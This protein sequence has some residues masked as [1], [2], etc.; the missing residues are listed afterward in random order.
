MAKAKKST[1][2]SGIP[3]GFD[4]HGSGS[5]GE[6]A[7]Q[8]PTDVAAKLADMLKQSAAQEHGDV[9]VDTNVPVKKIA[10]GKATWAG[11]MELPNGSGGV[12]AK[13]AVKTCKAVDTEK[14]ER[15]MYHSAECKHRAERGDMVC[16]GCGAKGLNE[17]NVVK[18]VELDGEV[19]LISDEELA[20]LVPQNEKTMRITEFVDGT[21][22]DPIYLE[23]T[24]FLY[25]Q[26][27]KKSKAAQ[28]TFAVLGDTLR[29]TGKVAKGVRVKRGKEQY[30]VVRPYGANGLTINMLHAE[31]EVRDASSLWLAVEAP[32]EMVEM[33]MALIETPELTKPFTP[34][35]RDQ[36]LAN[37][38]K[39]VADK[40][41]GIKT[42][43]PTPEP[44]QKGTDNLLEKLM[45]AVATNAAAKAAKA[46]K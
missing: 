42:E 37:A 29:G 26:E 17:Y 41:A 33:M 43:C 38:N 34:A 7:K 16:S 3:K 30:F 27:E 19:I 1:H 44:E 2:T 40:R 23:E 24:E 28:L 4:S 39:L 14:F 46:G 25:P 31:Y 18:G 15:H 22:I 11:V 5:V 8:N 20:A 35:K 13:F 32:R 6:P 45:A 9:N 21:E 36:Y 10:G 12:L